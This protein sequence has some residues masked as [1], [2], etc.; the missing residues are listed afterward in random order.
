MF[1]LDDFKALL[2][3]HSDLNKN[4]Y[5]DHSSSC[6]HISLSLMS[7]QVGHQEVSSR[8]VYLNILKLPLGVLFVLSTFGAIFFIF[9]G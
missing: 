7:T 5:S 9:K 2:L 8:G 1:L 6:D 4:I 3:N